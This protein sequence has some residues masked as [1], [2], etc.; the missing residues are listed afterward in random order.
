MSDLCEIKKF[1]QTEKQQI[2]TQDFSHFSEIWKFCLKYHETTTSIGFDML[3]F[4]NPLY[5]F[6]SHF[7]LGD[8][9]SKTPVV[10]GVCAHVNTDL[11]Y[12]LC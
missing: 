1:C 6:P 9:L 11:L 7:L 8:E 5:C 4:S 12:N 3:K 2:F 10:H